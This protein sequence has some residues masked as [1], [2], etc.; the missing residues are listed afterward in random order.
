MG[1]MGVLWQE[2]RRGVF[3]SLVKFEREN[4]FRKPIV[5]VLQQSAGGF[6]PGLQEQVQQAFLE[7]GISVYSSLERASRAMAK[8][9]QYHESQKEAQWDNY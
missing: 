3:D 9:I 4:A 5:I 2:L 8:L 6:S 1:R 7:A